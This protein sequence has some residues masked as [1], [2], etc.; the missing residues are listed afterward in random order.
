MCGIFAGI[1]VLLV[2]V[3]G[4]KAL[5]MLLSVPYHWLYPVIVIFC[6]IGSY[7]SSA[8]AFTLFATLGLTLLGLWM[9]YANIPASPFCLAFVLGDMVE[10][11]F[12]RALSYSNATI[13]TFFTRPVSCILLI[14]AFASLAWPYIREKFFA[15]KNL[16]ADDD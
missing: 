15:G 9:N 13:S 3:V 5:P 8:N 7:V 4:V 6:F 11:N 14:V 12:R 16:A 2:Q 1:F 10:M